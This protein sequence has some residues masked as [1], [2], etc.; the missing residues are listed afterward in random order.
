MKKLI[1]AIAILGFIFYGCGDDGGN[2]NDGSNLIIY[3]NN[4][5]DSD[6]NL[7]LDGV[8]IS[9]ISSCYCNIGF[10]S[11]EHPT[12]LDVQ[13]KYTN[14]NVACEWDCENMTGLDEMTY[15]CGTACLCD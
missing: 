9:M 8:L 2:G 14:G 15:T 3:I 12:C 5:T 10:E 11:D 7:F 13:L 4:Q 1:L 6:L